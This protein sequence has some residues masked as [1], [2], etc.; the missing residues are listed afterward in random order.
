MKDMFDGLLE[1]L[2][3]HGLEVQIGFQYEDSFLV[4]GHD[5]GQEFTIK[6]G[7][8]TCPRGDKFSLAHP[9]S[10]TT[11]ITGLKYCSDYLNWKGCK[12][13]PMMGESLSPDV[14]KNLLTYIGDNCV[15][16]RPSTDPGSKSDCDALC[17]QYG[18]YHCPLK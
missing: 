10:L 9:D 15:R 3:E 11:L 2:R 13:C 17:G 5:Y 16:V 18:I 8:I 14:S 7:I 4:G 1:Y 12:E 6:N